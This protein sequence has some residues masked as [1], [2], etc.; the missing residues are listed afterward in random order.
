M[1]EMLEE[2]PVHDPE[3]LK[4]FVSALT[5]EEIKELLEE[6]ERY[7][8][9]EVEIMDSVG[10]V[11]FHGDIHGDVDT[12]YKI[13]EQVGIEKVLDK[14]KLVFLGDYVD[15]GEYQLEALTLVLALKAMRPEEVVVLRGNHEPPEWLP[16]SPHDFPDVLVSKCGPSKGSEIYKVALQLFDSMPALAL[17]DDVVALHGGPPVSKVM[18]GCEGEDCLKELDRKSL[19]EVL[20]SDPDE[21]MGGKLCSWE[22]PP[23]LCVGSNPRGAGVVWGAGLTREFLERLGSKYIVRGHTAVDGFA[24]SH[25]NR[26]YTL[27][28]RSGPPYYNAN[29]AALL[30][31]RNSFNVIVVPAL[32]IL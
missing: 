18:E 24:L 1:I 27:F 20:W 2:V 7:F 29:A 30:L 12:L 16:P 31:K 13:W 15:R 28:T 22:D 4:N 10:G 5:C 8:G 6:A 17:I 23:K 9:R 11:L 21:L 3:E 32:P 25:N 14:F 19:E 26:V